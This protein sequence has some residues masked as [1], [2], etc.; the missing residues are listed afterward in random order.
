[1][2]QTK[3]SLLTLAAMFCLSATLL[4]QPPQPG[5]RP[6]RG[7]EG[8]GPGRG[9]PEMMNRM[10]QA[11]P[12]M[13]ALDANGDGE[14]SAEEIEGAAKALK[15]LDKDGD[16]KLTVA[17]IRPDFA[18]MRGGAGGPGGQGGGA[19]AMI[20]RMMSNDKNSDGKLSKDELP[21]RLQTMFDRVDGN[22][23]GFLDKSELEKMGSGRGGEG[24]RGGQGGGAGQR[25]RRP[26]GDEGD[27]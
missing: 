27:K 9:G 7:G 5:G 2:N 6:G 8:D 19:S 24:G 25:P 10:I 15:S 17:E 1:M 4:A 18:A 20:E 26:A 22:T 11:L 13:K 12:V 21:E 14:I 16:G 23:D 3:F